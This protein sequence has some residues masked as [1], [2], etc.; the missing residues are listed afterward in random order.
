LV[1]SPASNESET[2]SL[3]AADKRLLF[4][5]LCLSTSVLLFIKISFLE[6]RTAAFEFLQDR[7]QGLVLRILNELRFLSIPL[8]YLWKCTVVAFVLWVGCFMY[9]Y[10]V[11]YSQCW[12]IV[13]AAEFIFL[14][15]E[16]IKITWFMTAETDPA[17]H[18]IGTFYPLS[19]M[20]F[21]DYDSL[22][23]RLAY[24]L[25]ALNFF[26]VAYSFLL[27][28]GIHYYAGK[29]KSVAWLIVTC[30]YIFLFFLRLVFYYIVY[31]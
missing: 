23:P 29:D 19:L 16:I 21:F 11:T 13:I 1:N 22:D 6:N 17:Y 14:I 5:L 8:V 10:R 4:I 24:P 12:G 18:E 20:H 30:S 27:V 25:R 2:K 31:K 3:F 26:E 9:G 28:E 15:P 7:P